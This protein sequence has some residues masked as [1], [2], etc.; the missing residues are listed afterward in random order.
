[1]SGHKS[2]SFVFRNGSRHASTAAGDAVSLVTRL[3]NLFFGT[4]II[5]GGVFIY[6]YVTDARGGLHRWIVVPGL[7]AIYP[8]A[9]EAHRA[10]NQCLKAL[11]Q[12]G[13]YPRE[14]GNPD[15]A[16]DLQAEVRTLSR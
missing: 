7:R 11:Y 16:G 5:L 4:S 1:L 13:I 3:K 8:D 12:F 6:Y 10:A 15:A 2:T 9:E 14:R